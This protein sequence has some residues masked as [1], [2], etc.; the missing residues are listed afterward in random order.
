[1]PKFSPINA[2]IPGKKVLRARL[3]QCVLFGMILAGLAELHWNPAAAWLVE[4]TQPFVFS[5]TTSPRLRQRASQPAEWIPSK[6][7]SHIVAPVEGDLIPKGAVLWKPG[8]RV[9]QGQVLAVI[10]STE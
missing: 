5:A 6:P 7:L 1:M 10:W 4:F 3:R 9:R 2:L 8:D